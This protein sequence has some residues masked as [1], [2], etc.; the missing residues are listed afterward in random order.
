MTQ[1][2]DHRHA[3]AEDILRLVP[4]FAAGFAPDRQRQV[5][6]PYGMRADAGRQRDVFVVA[7]DG[8]IKTADCRLPSLRA[9]LTLC[10][11]PLTVRQNAQTP[12]LGLSGSGRD[13]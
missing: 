4:E 3:D 2:L 12:L 7:V 10:G 5:A 6:C 9:I 11:S 13:G 8:L 1:E